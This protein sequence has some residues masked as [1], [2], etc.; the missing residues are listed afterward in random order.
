MK[1]TARLLLIALV[2]GLTGA[3]AQEKAVPLYEGPIPG[4]EKWSHAEKAIEAPG[5]GTIWHDVARPTLTPFPADPAK[6][7]GTAVI[8]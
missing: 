6:A 3:S 5:L 2:S 7:T 4:S 1:S 8:I